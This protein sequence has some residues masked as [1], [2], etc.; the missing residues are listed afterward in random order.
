MLI[1]LYGQNPGNSNILFLISRDNYMNITIVAG[2][3][4]NFI[5]ISPIINSIL[6]RQNEGI[7]IHFR[8]VHTGQHFDN[9]MSQIFFDELR[10]PTPHVNLYCGGGTQTEQVASIMVKFEKEILS[11]TPDLLLVV[12]D[13]NSTMAAA[14]V[15]KKMQIKVAHVEAGI[16]SF[17]LSMPE[18]INRL[19]TDSITDYFFTTSVYANQNL[20]NAGVSESQ[21]FFVGNT[22]ID[23]LYK[24]ISRFTKPEVFVMNNLKNKSYFVLTLHRPSNVDCLDS[25]FLI[26]DVILQNTNF[27]V[28]FP[29]HPRTKRQLK[30][31]SYSFSNLII[32]EPLGYLEFNYLVTNSFAVITDSGGITE[33]TTV[34]GIPCMTL[35]TNTERPETCVVGTN[36]LVGSDPNDIKLAM[37]RLALGQW[38]SGSIPELWDGKSADRIVDSL[39]N[40]FS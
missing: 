22:M 27:P 38:K 4:P 20:L 10:I 18:E 9:K 24:N 26:L 31:L 33:E 35:R 37:N 40:I 2:A 1:L 11:Y 21:I 28:I 15:A 29:V 7:N 32:C 39:L 8:L 36:E 5:K 30:S 23:T 12:G 25:L 34:L 13:V 14:I 6:N 19:V 16:R 17:D 3:R